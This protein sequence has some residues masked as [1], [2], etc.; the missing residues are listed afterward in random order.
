[1]N[2]F[3]QVNR[4]FVY[5]YGRELSWD[6]FGVNGSNALGILQALDRM[7]NIDTLHHGGL[8]Q[9]GC[10]GHIMRMCP[11]RRYLGDRINIHEINAFA[12][13]TLRSRTA[14]P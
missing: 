7:G 6:D 11:Q 3:D 9:C 13:E 10:S 1:M 14:F 5:Y 12:N 8:K 2:T 4:L